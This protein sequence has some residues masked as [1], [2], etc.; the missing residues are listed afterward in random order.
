MFSR[1]LGWRFGNTAT[2]QQKE[3]AYTDVLRALSEQRARI[4]R[5]L[6]DQ[7]AQQI[8]LIKYNL[9]SIKKDF[10]P[11]SKPAK[12]DQII[13]DVDRL[14]VDLQ[15]VVSGLRPVQLE[16]YGLASSLEEL[17]VDWSGRFGV[18]ASIDFCGAATAIDFTIETVL[19][20]VAQEALTNIAKHASTASQVTVILQCTDEQI[21]LSVEDNGGG[22][23]QPSSN[24]PKG[25]WGLVGL[26]ERLALVGGTLE[27]SSKP[28]SGALII[29][30][31]PLGAE[32]HERER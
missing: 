28:D 4:S 3:S 27:T 31:I 6:H 5:D 13:K 32:Q 24:G 21:V 7:T 18:E 12:L 8:A 15:A 9:E 14:A 16:A 19:Y 20:H 17:V 22:F 26:R 25:R 1:L 2:F 29:A 10:L 30:R 11:H 23:E